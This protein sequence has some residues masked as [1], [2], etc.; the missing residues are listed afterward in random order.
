MAA[1][2]F[3]FSASRSTR[4]GRCRIQPRVRCA[5]VFARSLCSDSSLPLPERDAELPQTLDAIKIA[6][7]WYPWWEG[8]GKFKSR[9][10]RDGRR[11]NMLL[12]PP[13]VTGTLHVGHALT[14]A[15]Q[16]SLARWRRLNG[17]EV[18]W[19]P[20]TDHAGIATQALVE[21]MLRSRVRRYW[22]GCHP[23]LAN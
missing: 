16:D 5:V 14:V 3:A 18:T 15:I 22:L 9:T 4:L 2:A 1:L 21:N 11:F 23:F 6:R 19:I 7:R 13:N 20:G 10:S 17:D 8:C 12:P